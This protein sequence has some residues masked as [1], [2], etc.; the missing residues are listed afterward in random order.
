MKLL[1]PVVAL[2]SSLALVGTAA[3][4]APDLNAQSAAMKKL[5][6]LVGQWSGPATVVRG[7]AEALKI[8]QTEEVRYAVDGLV[9]LVEGTGR[10]SDGKAC[11]MRSPQSPTTKLHRRIILAR[12]AMVDTSMF[13]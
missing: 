8:T 2:I 12:T 9:L 1:G 10:N 13:R 4:Q 3:A 7:P 6:F 11:S 5:Q